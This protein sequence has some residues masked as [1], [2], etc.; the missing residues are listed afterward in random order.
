MTPRHVA[1][2]QPRVTVTSA[3]PVSNGT[4]SVHRPF[5]NGIDLAILVVRGGIEADCIET[6]D[7][8]DTSNAARSANEAQLLRL[9][10]SGEAE[11]V[12]I[13]ISR[14]EYL[15]LQAQVTGSD[16]DVYQGTS[17]AFAFVR[18]EPMGMAITSGASDQLTLMRS[19]EIALNVTRY[20]SAHGATFSSAN[21][22]TPPV[23]AGQIP[24]RFISAT[25]AP[26]SPEFSPENVLTSGSYVFAPQRNMEII[27]K[28]D[29]PD[30]LP[31]RQ[32][33]ITSNPETAYAL[34]KRILI[35]TDASENGDRY[36]VWTRGEVAPDGIFDTGQMAARNARW[37]K[38]QILDSWEMGEVTIDKIAAF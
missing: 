14:R 29:G 24:L 18:D 32:L 35:S 36:R 20:L 33:L 37:I 4:G 5:W 15:T 27:L 23:E 28:V 16:A 8:L 2:E 1:G 12:T 38:V 9:D 22:P 30:P 26:T 34:P 19:E 6:L 25:A 31:V 13:T 17:G 7:R 21:D 3:S 10:A 11:R